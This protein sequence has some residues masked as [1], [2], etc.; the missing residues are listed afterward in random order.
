MGDSH[1]GELQWYRRFL[2]I[3]CKQGQNIFRGM[4]YHCIYIHNNSASIFPSN[5][6]QQSPLSP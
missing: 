6:Y 2:H 4:I 5:I 3:H 1:L